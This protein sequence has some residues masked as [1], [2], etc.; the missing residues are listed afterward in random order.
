MQCIPNVFY[1]LYILNKLQNLDK[2]IGP[3]MFLAM[4]IRVIDIPMK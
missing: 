3:K 4:L 1:I 2:N